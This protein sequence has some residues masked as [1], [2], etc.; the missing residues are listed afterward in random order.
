MVNESTGTNPKDEQEEFENVFEILRKQLLS[1]S[2]NFSIWEQ[3]FPTDKVVDIINRYIGFFQPTREAHL[4][5]LIIKISEILSNGGNA[6]SFYRILNMIGRNPNLAPSINV[7]EIR[8]CLRNH[9]KVVEAIKDYRNKRVAHWDTT[10]VKERVVPEYAGIK[11]LGKP[12]FFGETKE[13]LAELQAIYNKISTSH[14]QEIHAFKYGQHRDTINLLEALRKRIA[15]DKKLIE[16][17]Q[18]K[19]KHENEGLNCH[20]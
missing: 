5:G 10:G 6:A 14:S 20:E 1:A 9:K 18:N 3:L 12:V 16:D 7:H 8:K 17:W 4:D 13:M 19:I 15:E 11:R 2:V